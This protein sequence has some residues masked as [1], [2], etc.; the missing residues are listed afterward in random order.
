MK[1]RLDGLEKRLGNAVADLNMVNTALLRGEV[2]PPDTEGTN[3][4][5]R[6]KGVTSIVTM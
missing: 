2:A 3:R 6:P 4:P 1:A 5:I